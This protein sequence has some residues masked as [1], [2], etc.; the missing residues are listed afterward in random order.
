MGLG[1]THELRSVIVQRCLEASRIR[2]SSIRVFG[3]AII[4]HVSREGVE[5]RVIVTV[6]P[7]L[8][9]TQTLLMHRADAASEI[10]ACL[11]Q[12]LLEK[13]MA[14]IQGIFALAA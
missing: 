11:L 8:S 13:D 3:K 2:F 5:L 6:Q 12:G 7:Q 14:R 9:F 10:C 4:A 1:T